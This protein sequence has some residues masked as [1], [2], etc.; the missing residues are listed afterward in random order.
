M[1]KL[2]TTLCIIY[3]TISTFAVPG[4]KVQVQCPDVV[5]SWPS[6]E[7][8]SYLVYYRPD[9]NPGTTWQLLSIM[10]AD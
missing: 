3:L 10:A 1:K 6:T 4:L 7:G 5:L 8:A 2:T 9:L